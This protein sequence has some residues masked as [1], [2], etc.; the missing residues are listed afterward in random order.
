MIGMRNRKR[1]PLAVSHSL[2]CSIDKEARS[3]NQI[4][5]EI[6]SCDF[7]CKMLSQLIFQPVFSHFPSVVFAHQICITSICLS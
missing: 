6:Q 4:W 1:P 3:R 2:T 5:T 7:V